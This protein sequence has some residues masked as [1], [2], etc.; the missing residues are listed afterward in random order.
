MAGRH[1]RVFE[2]HGNKTIVLARFVPIVR[3]IAPFVSGIGK[4]T[5]TT[6]TLYNILGAFLWIVSMVTLGHFLGSYSFVKD[7]LEK[8]VL[9]IVF[10]SILPM[11]IKA[12]QLKLKK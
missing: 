5:Y 9:G 6:F 1:A 4:M 8:F 10:L 7:N 3:T 11:I 12:I 2:K